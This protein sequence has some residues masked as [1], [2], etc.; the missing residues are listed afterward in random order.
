MTI[1]EIQSSN[2]ADQIQ[3]L[4][5]NHELYPSIVISGRNRSYEAQFVNYKHPDVVAAKAIENLHS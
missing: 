2:H 5:Q 1:S 4:V 3:G